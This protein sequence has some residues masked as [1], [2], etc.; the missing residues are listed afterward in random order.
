MIDLPNKRILITGGAG[1]FGTHIVKELNNRGCR[2]IL[3]P[4]SKV[5][6]LRNY[7]DV[8]YMFDTLKPQIVIHAA[9]HCGGIGLNQAR[10]AELFFDNMIM[11]TLMIDEAYKGGVE[12]FVQLGTVCEYPKFTEA[13]FIEEDLWDGYP[14]ETNAPYGVAKKALLV[15]GQA[16]R[17]QYGF[18]VIHLL[19]VNLYGPGDNFDLQSSHVIPALIRK[20]AEAKENKVSSVTIWGSG[21]AS[22]EFLYVEDAAEAVVSATAAYDWGE[23][24][25]IGS[26]D[27]I[28]IQALTEIIA[29]KIDYRGEILFDASK[30]DGQPHRCLDIQKARKAFGFEAK[31][32]LKKGLDKTIEWWY[33]KKVEKL[34]VSLKCNR[35]GA[36][37]II[38]PTNNTAFCNFHWGLERANV[39]A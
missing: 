23:P 39:N 22:R 2:N 29:N 4:R 9:A 26:G 10:P 17:K 12:K 6:D 21:T 18:N 19:P 35:C 7:D 14:E 11:G 33:S 8:R 37:A 36:L 1:F 30:P 16:Y 28:T 27:E 13:P 5:Y 3:I 15:Q 20:F 24:I 32:D 25:N 38:W 31:N 34:P